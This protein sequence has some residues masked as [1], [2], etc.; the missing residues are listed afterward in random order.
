MDWPLLGTEALASGA[1]TRGQLRWNYRAILPNVYVPSRQPVT[2]RVRTVA[3]WL[4][5]GRT[6]VVA[7]RAAAELHGASWMPDGAPVELLWRRPRPPAGIVVRNERFDAG[8]IMEIGGMYV[9][10]PARTA[11]DLSRHLAPLA[12]VTSLD[13]L[14]RATGVDAASAL[15]LWERYPR[16]RGRVRSRQ[17]LDLM[18]AGAQSPKE[19]WLRL[20]LIEYGF[21]R[22][23]TQIRVGDGFSEAFLD[24]GWEGAKIGVDYDG[25][26]HRTD[27][28]RYVHDIGRNELVAREGWIDVHVVAEHSRRFIVHRV[29]EAFER[30]GWSRD[31]RLRRDCG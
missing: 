18:D 7:G 27:R 23:T 4:W 2:L 10:T 28:R 20:L 22:P 14:A 31:G 9:T 30:R 29:G 17:A 26:Q 19:T 12:A 24:M 5:S 1:L 16:A 25:D 3:A 15:T 6:A 13:S 11:Y 21:P 8:E